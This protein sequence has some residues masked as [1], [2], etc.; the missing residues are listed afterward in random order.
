MDESRTG[1]GGPG[2][3]EEEEGCEDI[4]RVTLFGVVG[5]DMFLDM[6]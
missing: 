6:C 1:T 4:E 3:V 2:A 5:L